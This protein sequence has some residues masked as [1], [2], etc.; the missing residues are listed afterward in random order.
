MKKLNKA[1]IERCCL[2]IARRMSPI[3]TGN[4]RYNAIYS[5]RRNKSIVIGW[6]QAF[7]YYLPIVDGNGDFASY[8]MPQNDRDFLSMMQEGKYIK[9]GTKEKNKGFVDRSIANIVAWLSAY[10]IGNNAEASRDLSS[11]ASLNAPSGPF[12]NSLIRQ[13]NKDKVDNIISM[14]KNMQRM[15][16]RCAYSIV[17]IDDDRYIGYFGVG[18]K[19]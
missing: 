1:H 19:D 14:D 4:M 10:T 13:L 16:D 9:K 18:Y 15:L 6:D 8:V 3:D 7:A 17:N 5:F 2:E 12:V 11:E